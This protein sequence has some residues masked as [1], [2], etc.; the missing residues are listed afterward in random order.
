VTN[1]PTAHIVSARQEHIMFGSKVLWVYRAALYC[2]ESCVIEA[3]TFGQPDVAKHSTVAWYA[4]AAGIDMDDQHSYD[5]DVFPKPV[6]SQEVEQTEW[7]EW[8][9]CCCLCGG[10]VGRSCGH[11][12]IWCEDCFGPCSQCEQEKAG[13]PAHIHHYVE[14]RDCDGVVERSWIAVCPLSD[15]DE[16]ARYRWWVEEQGWALPTTSEEPVTIE[17]E[18]MKSMRYTE[19]T[20]EGYR[21]LEMQY[22]EDACDLTEG[23][24][25]DH[26]AEAA[27]Y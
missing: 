3:M 21:R 1:Q 20:D 2:G 10:R 27:G 23:S 17:F 22:C 8:C 9:G 19:P 13:G 25:R 5:S 15:D 24:Y 18:F 12:P 7:C 11:Q 4:D 6:L 26:A 14:A 16:H